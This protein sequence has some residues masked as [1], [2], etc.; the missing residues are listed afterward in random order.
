[1]SGLKVVDD[2]TFTI[3]LNNPLPYFAYKLGYDGLLAAA[4][5]LLQG[6]EGRR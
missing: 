1:M 3:E 4:R 2:N 6:P 5:V